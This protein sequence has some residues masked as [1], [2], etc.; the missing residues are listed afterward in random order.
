SRLTCQHAGIRRGGTPHTGSPTLF[1]G[2]PPWLGGGTTKA[3]DGTGGTG[4][5]DR[6]AAASARPFG[7]MAGRGRAAYDGRRAAEAVGRGGWA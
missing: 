5:K 7:R 3:G 4:F 1:A 6:S 2:A